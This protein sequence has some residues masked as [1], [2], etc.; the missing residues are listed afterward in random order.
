MVRDSDTLHYQVYPERKIVQH[1]CLLKHK[2]HTFGD[3]VDR[4]NMAHVRILLR[5]DA[6]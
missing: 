1:S 2:N 6:A 4:P 5:R 3:E